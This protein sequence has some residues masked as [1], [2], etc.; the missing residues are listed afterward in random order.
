MN[1]L[2]Y[3]F[4]LNLGDILEVTINTTANVRIMDPVNFLY[5]RHKRKYKYIG[6]LTT[7]PLFT[8]SVPYKG[9]WHVVIDLEGLSGDV[10][11]AVKVIRT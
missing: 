11:A 10:R 8:A 4:Q 3:D 7:P 2:Q 9:R 6:G 5:Y 1:F